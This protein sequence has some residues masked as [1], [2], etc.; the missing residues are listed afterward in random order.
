VGRPTQRSVAWPSPNPFLLLDRSIQ[1]QQRR[2]EHVALAVEEIGCVCDLKTF[3]GAADQGT[4]LVAGHLD[5]L[6]GHALCTLVDGRLPGLG[7]AV[8]TIALDENEVGHRLDAHQAGSAA[9]EVFVGNQ[10]DGLGL[11]QLDKVGL[12]AVAEGNQV[13]FELS[14]ERMEGTTGASNKA[15]ELRASEECANGTNAA[16]ALELEGDQE[17]KED[18]AE[19]QLTSGREEERGNG[20]VWGW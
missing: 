3:L 14:G 20:V 4:G 5:D 15:I 17:S 19:D 2:L 13:R 16:C 7:I 18:V 12:F 10:C 6:D 8:V 9:V 1:W 11:H